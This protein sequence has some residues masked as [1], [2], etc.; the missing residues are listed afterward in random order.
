MVKEKLTRHIPIHF[1]CNGIG[2][3][4]IDN[5]VYVVIVNSVSLQDHSW[6]EGRKG[7]IISNA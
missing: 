2:Y 3:H 5:R 1:N 6:E 7:R 4:M